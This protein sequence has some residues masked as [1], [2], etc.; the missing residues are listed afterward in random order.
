MDQANSINSEQLTE[1]RI[2]V[3]VIALIRNKTRILVASGYD[4]VKQQVFYRA[5]GGGVEFGETSLDALKR[6]FQEEIQAELTQ[7]QYLGCIENLFVFNGKPGHELVQVYQCDLADPRFYEVET[8]L[9]QESW[10]QESSTPFTAHWIEAERFKFGELRLV[11][12][13]CLAYL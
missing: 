3:I 4:Q 10:G 9:G 1:Q 11:P 13:A 8:I 7:I 5:L 12:E 2:R 6:E